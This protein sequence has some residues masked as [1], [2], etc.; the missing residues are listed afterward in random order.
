MNHQDA[1]EV[2]ELVAAHRALLRQQGL[3]PV[4]IWVPDVRAP[5]FAAE[6]LRQSALAAASAHAAEDQTF[7]DSISRLSDEGDT[8]DAEWGEANPGLPPGHALRRQAVG[9]ARSLRRFFRRDRLDLSRKFDPPEADIRMIGLFLNASVERA[10]GV[11]DHRHVSRMHLSCAPG[12][13][14]RV[15]AVGALAFFADTHAPDCRSPAYRIRSARRRVRS[16]WP[17]AARASRRR[18]SRCCAGS[19]PPSAPARL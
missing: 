8:E 17:A 6:A 19:A 15:I 11:P 10:T 5:G 3:R 7:V 13:R 14:C 12:S 9:G 18:R 2:R 4:Q 1:S 16:S